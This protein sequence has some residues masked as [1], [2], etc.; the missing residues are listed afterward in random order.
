[1]LGSHFKCCRSP[2]HI[3]CVWTL[4]Q[5]SLVTALSCTVNLLNGIMESSMLYVV[6]MLHLTLLFVMA[7]GHGL[8]H[9][10]PTWGLMIVTHDDRS[11][12]L[13]YSIQ[14]ANM[15]EQCKPC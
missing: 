6:S 12:E 2:E 14:Y 10:S 1:M 4:H 3:P 13:F 7:T 15:T 11:V 8:F 9:G 5:L